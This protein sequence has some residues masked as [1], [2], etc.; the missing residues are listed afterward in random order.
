MLQFASGVSAVLRDHH[1]A[2]P[3]VAPGGLKDGCA[4]CRGT[5][6]DGGTAATQQRQVPGHRDRL[7]ADPSLWQSGEQADHPGQSGAGRAR[8]HHEELRLREA[9]MDHFSSA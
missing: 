7:S 3:T 8:A 4:A 5:A 6:E 9:A 1:A 2:Q